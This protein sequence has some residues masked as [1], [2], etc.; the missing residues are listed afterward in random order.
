M[1]LSEEGSRVAQIEMS[2]LRMR[3]AAKFNRDSK[4]NSRF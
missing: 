1:W 4:T 3:K 2:K